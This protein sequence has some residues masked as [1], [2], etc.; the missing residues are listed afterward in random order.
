MF[1]EP[2]I[3][4]TISTCS[5]VQHGLQL[6]TCAQLCLWCGRLS[7]AVT[8]VL[9]KSC[10]SIAAPLLFLFWRSFYFLPSNSG[11]AIECCRWKWIFS[12]I[13]KLLPRPWCLEPGCA[14][15]HPAREMAWLVILCTEMGV[16]PLCRGEGR[17]VLAVVQAECHARVSVFECV[18]AS[19][20][21]PAKYRLYITEF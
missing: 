10:L 15:A 17:T 21:S 12:K 2:N 16:E 14:L 1:V 3:Q 6:E 7:W 4:S 18:C 20:I 13:F 19:V 5:K 11:C 8:K 9:Y